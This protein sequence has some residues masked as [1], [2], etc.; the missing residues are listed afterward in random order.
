[1]HR[2]LFATSQK[3]RK[4][5]RK[6]TDYEAGYYFN[7]ATA[8]EDVDGEHWLGDSGLFGSFFFVSSLLEVINGLM[9]NGNIFHAVEV[10]DQ[11]SPIHS[12]KN[13]I[14]FFIIKM[15]GYAL[16]GMSG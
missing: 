7:K 6:H 11:F 1:M 9:Q 14:S 3:E 4:K 15:H 10:S 12:S 8:G 16:A 13:A 2:V 5:N